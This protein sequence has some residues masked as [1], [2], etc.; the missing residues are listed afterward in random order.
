MAALAALTVTASACSTTSSEVPV[1]R[2]VALRPQIPASARTPCAAPVGLPDRDLSQAEVA[3]GWGKDRSAL[4]A[5]EAR[6]RS[7]VTAL[8]GER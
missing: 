2:T 8:D 7:L 3:S 5:C 6:R 4:R 1:I